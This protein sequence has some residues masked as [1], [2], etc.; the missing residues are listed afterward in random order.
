MLRVFLLIF[1]V[2]PRDQ[3]Y[4]VVVV[5]VAALNALMISDVRRNLLDCYSASWWLG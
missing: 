4:D 2:I 3:S 1:L 5:A